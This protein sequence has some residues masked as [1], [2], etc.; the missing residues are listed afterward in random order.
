M[1]PDP[2]VEEAR[3]AGRELFARFDGDMHSVCEF[4]R[5]QAKDSGHK[6]TSRPPKQPADLLKKKKGG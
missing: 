2:I 3:K 1:K 4:L 5:R 6:T